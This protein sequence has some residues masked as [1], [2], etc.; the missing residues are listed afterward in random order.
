MACFDSLGLEALKYIIT[1]RVE[2]RML[3][4]IGKADAVSDPLMI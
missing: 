4:W 2:Y 1:I 3:G